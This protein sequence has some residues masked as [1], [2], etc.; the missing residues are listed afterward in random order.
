MS[1]QDPFSDFQRLTQEAEHLANQ[2]AQFQNELNTVLEQHA[3][4]KI[5]NKYLR[6]RLEQLDQPVGPVEANQN[7][8]SS[9]RNLEKLYES[10]YHVCNV[11]YGQRRKNQEECAFCLDKIYS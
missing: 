4:L 6:Q 9:R 5:E 10:G 7:M 8:R 2:L 3:E 11:M 1:S